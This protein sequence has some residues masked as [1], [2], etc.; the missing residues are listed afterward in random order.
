VLAL[1]MVSPDGRSGA[2]MVSMGVGMTQ[3]WSAFEG[4]VALTSNMLD[5][6]GSVFLESFN[7]AREQGQ[8][9]ACQSNL[10]NIGT[11]CEMYSTDHAGRYPKTLAELVPDYLQAIPTCPAA[12][13]DTYSSTYKASTGPDRFELACSG[14][15]HKQRRDNLP[16][17]NSVAGLDG[18]TPLQAPQT[19]DKLPSVVVTA[20][21]KDATFAHNLIAKLYPGAGSAPKAGQDKNYDLPPGQGTLRLKTAAPAR[22]IFSFGDQAEQL[23]DSKGGTLADQSLLKQA[24]QWGGDGIVYADYTDL[25]PLMDS[26]SK[27]VSQAE[28][29]DKELAQTILDKLKGVDL[30]GA[31]CLAVRPDGL[32]WHSFGAFSGG[33]MMTGGVAAAILVPNFVRA[34]GQGQETACKSNLKNIGTALEMWSTDHSGKYPD[35]LS[36]LTPDYLKA[37]PTCPVSGTDTYSASYSKHKGASYD[38]FTIFCQGHNHEAVGLPPDYPRYDAEQGLIERPF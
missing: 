34:R 5:M 29:K 24:L 17:Y 19:P 2:A 15:H 25:Q 26:L 23:L 14:N 10:K 37:I 30:K 12:G 16:A 31:S 38:S 1:V 32:E 35:S 28:P 11:A 22:L 3:P 9:T 13:S 8:L 21:V 7:G 4:D 20:S 27:A 6:A 33:V 36:Q 18:G